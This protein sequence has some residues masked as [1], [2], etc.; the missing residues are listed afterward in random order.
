MIFFGPTDIYTLPK[1]FYVNPVQQQTHRE[2]VP[3]SQKLLEDV[4]PQK[5]TFNAKKKLYYYNHTHSFSQMDQSPKM[6]LW[7]LWSYGWHLIFYELLDDF[8]RVS[9]KALIE[10]QCDYCSLR[11]RTPCKKR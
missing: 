7:I 4:T 5:L 6:Y 11:R 1:I 3:K 8:N 10:T 9:R 2:L